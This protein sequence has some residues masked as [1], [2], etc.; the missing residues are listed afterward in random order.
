MYE[1]LINNL[2]NNFS[3]MGARALIFH[4]SIPCEKTYLW[5]PKF[6]IWTLE[7][8]LLF[9]NFNLAINIW[10]VSAKTLI[11]HMNIPCDNTK[12]FDLDIWHIF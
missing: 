6:P 10:T 7:L 9:E 1:T 8:D 12:A 5:V 2:A 3:T 4:M 11:F